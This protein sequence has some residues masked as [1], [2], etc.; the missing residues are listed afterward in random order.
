MCQRS[1]LLHRNQ[2]ARVSSHTGQLAN[3]WDAH[4]GPATRSIIS[5]PN[6]EILKVK[7]HEASLMYN[8][9]VFIGLIKEIREDVH[10]VLREDHSD[11]QTVYE[12]TFQQIVTRWYQLDLCNHL[13]KRPQE[14]SSRKRPP[15]KASVV[16]LRKDALALTT[17]WSTMYIDASC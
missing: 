15:K 8:S 11:D 3:F 5:R 4:T 2:I 13:S 6:L 1:F 10:G 16:E 14:K 12:S 17:S 7:Y 9:T